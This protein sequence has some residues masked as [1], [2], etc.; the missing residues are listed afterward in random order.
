MI[1]LGSWAL[2]A[3]AIEW[4]KDSF[5]H[6]ST[7]LELG[8]G[9][10]TGVLSKYFKMISIEHDERFLNKYQSDYIHAPIKDGWYDS[11]VMTS[12]VPQISYD[13][14]IVDGP[15]R[16][17]GREGMLFHLNLFRNDR[18]ALFDD[19]QTCLP[20]LDNFARHINAIPD[21]RRCDVYSYRKFAIL[22][23][24]SRAE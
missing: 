15:P 11:K 5:D 22:L 8:S 18:P 14:L 17:I 1:S 20:V 7:I 12:K 23:P 6:G 4:I 16:I 24:E 10:G 19:V 9:Q 2:P 3:K 21:V 13:L